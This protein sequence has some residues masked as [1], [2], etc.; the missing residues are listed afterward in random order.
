MLYEHLASSRLLPITPSDLTTRVWDV[1]NHKKEWT[2]IAGGENVAK[3][4]REF[5][6]TAPPDHPPPERPPP[7]ERGGPMPK[8]PRGAGPYQAEATRKTTVLCRDDPVN[9]P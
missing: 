6:F 8:D 3:L 2:D 5:E 1:I 4:F 7:L 9:F